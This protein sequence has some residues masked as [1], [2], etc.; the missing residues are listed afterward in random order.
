MSSRTADRNDTRDISCVCV[1]RRG[2]DQLTRMG[3]T[4]ISQRLA[5][6]A[7]AA[8]TCEHVL[9][10]HGVNPAVT[11]I[12]A[13]EDDVLDSHTGAADRDDR[14]L[15]QPAAYGTC[16]GT[17]QTPSI[18]GWLVPFHFDTFSHCN[19]FVRIEVEPSRQLPWGC[20]REDSR[21]GSSVIYTQMLPPSTWITVSHRTW[22]FVQY[23]TVATALRMSVSGSD[24]GVRETERER[25]AL[26]ECFLELNSNPTSYVMKYIA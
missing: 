12:E 7:G 21:C 15:L 17:W 10:V 1:L 6:S 18:D 2:R 4:P 22:R 8:C 16:R 23:S 11:R 9:D 20:G 24:D 5:R 25:D 19:V 3:V 26:K 13:G 14:C